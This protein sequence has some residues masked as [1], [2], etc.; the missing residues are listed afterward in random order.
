MSTVLIAALTAPT[1]ARAEANISVQSNKP[2][3]SIE[4]KYD[5]KN[6][7]QKEKEE[8]EKC[9][10]FH[11]RFRNRIS[12]FNKLLSKAE[13]ITNENKAAI[14]TAVEKQEA[15][16][17]E[18]FKITGANIDE[19]DE[20]D[21]VI[22]QKMKAI[23]EKAKSGTITEDEARK[24]MADL[25]RE[26]SSYWHRLSEEGQNEIKAVQNEMDKSREAKRQAMDSFK[27]AIEDK[28][29]DAI[30]SNA[31]KVADSLNLQ[32]K[33]LQKELDILNKYLK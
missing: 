23:K 15:L 6:S 14:E 17:R 20:C 4:E 29:V 26:Y 27:K 18:I 2:S 7:K 16:Y 31:K 33:L 24:Q 32:N 5:D 25:R 22:K 1:L 21:K 8:E 28:N 11:G 9:H 12:H 10:G 13:G 30:N 3:T 19:Q